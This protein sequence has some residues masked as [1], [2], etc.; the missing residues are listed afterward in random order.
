M[1]EAEP[2][3]YEILRGLY[4]GETSNADLSRASVVSTLHIR[5]GLDELIPA[6]VARGFDIVVTGNQGDGKSHLIRHLRFE[7]KLGGA[8]VQFDLS[9]SRNDEV[10][11]NWRAAAA[12]G[13]CFVLCANEGP[14]RELLDT[15]REG[16]DQAL[17]SRESE[18]SAQLGRLLVSDPVTLPF[19]PRKAA[20]VDL[21]DRSVLE[22][23]L[24]E[25]A[26]GRVCDRQFLPPLGAQSTACAPGRNIMLLARSRDVRGR[27][28]RVLAVGGRALGEH[29]TFRQLWQA[30]SLA[31]TGGKAPSTL[32]VELSRGEVGLGSFP[33]D[34]LV[35]SSGRGPLVDA[36]R[37]L[38]DPAGVTD[39]DLDEE[40]WTRGRPRRGSWLVEDATL[41]DVLP[42]DPPVQLAEGGRLEDALDVLRQLK[43]LLSIVHEEGERLVRRLEERV[44]AQFLRGR[45]ADVAAVLGGLRRLYLTATAESARR[46][47]AWL[48]EGLPLWVS[49]T[50]VDAAPEARPHVAVATLAPDEFEL[51]QPVRAP[52]LGAALGPAPEIA[53][54]F[55]RESRIGLRVD[56]SLM[57]HLE[58]AR[59]STGPLSIPEPVQR[60]LY[61]L[62]GYEE[63][64]DA[65]RVG[66]QSF[67]VLERPRG[68]LVATGEVRVA[69]RG[70]ASYG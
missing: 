23:R 11:A 30:V 17:A 8:E 29:V 57:A 67:A 22:M 54:L 61:R 27:L 20:L 26:L 31:I 36:V 69:A 24:I 7:G 15:M 43:R 13:K 66:P 58:L 37:R 28:A 59:R 34:N 2:T 4:F 40:L 49:N 44:G 47:D 48:S 6:L 65:G 70:G 5:T 42:T 35:R 9:A 45:R 14:L 60:F 25:D 63:S 10:L 46:E 12:A 56:A 38:A 3:G 50:Y 39:P 64:T 55:H 19:E 18:L 32:R 1:T 68:R 62:A 53:W 33:V 41:D 21:A 52:W 16:T 51:L